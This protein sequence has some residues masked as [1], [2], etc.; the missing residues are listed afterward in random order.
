[1]ST[2]LVLQVIPQAEDLSFDGKFLEALVATEQVLKVFAR[3][4]RCLGTKLVLWPPFKNGACCDQ[5]CD[6]SG[7]MQH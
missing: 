3:I 2:Y 1:M 6:P 4:N 7:D 5:F